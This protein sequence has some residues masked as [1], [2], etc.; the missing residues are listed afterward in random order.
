MGTRG[1]WA[2]DFLYALG[3]PLPNSKVIALVSAWTKAEAGEGAKG[4]AYNPLN[5]KLEY[6]KWTNFNSVGVKNYADRQTGINATVQSFGPRNAAIKRALVSNDAEGALAAMKASQ[7]GTNMG[8]VE[9]IYRTQTITSEPLP[10]EENAD[11]PSKG[12][13]KASDKPPNSP[14]TSATSSIAA[15]GDLTTDDV[16]KF[17]YVYLGVVLILLGGTLIIIEVGRH[18]LT[19][20]VTT[21]I[22]TGAV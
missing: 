15:G 12:D 17:L 21:A 7:W 4:A 11:K 22:R 5:T 8:L 2:R 16:R 10:A 13:G 14:Q 1:Q 18:P 20:A 9:S 3:N 6:G 19:R